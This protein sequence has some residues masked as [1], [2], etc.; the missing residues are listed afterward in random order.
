MSEP[1]SED[2][3]V[4]GS[5]SADLWISSDAEDTDLEVT[6]V[7]ARADGTEVLVQSGWLRASQRAL[8]QAASTELN[9]V[10]THIEADAAP[11]PAGELVPVRVDIFPFAH[12]FRVGSRLLVSIDAPGG[13]RQ[14]WLFDTIS[15]G[16]TV[17]IAFGAEHPSRIV[18]ATLT[19]IDF[20][21]DYPACGT[22]R[23]QPCRDG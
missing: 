15:D 17:D 4:M 8:D 13:N 19:G 18:L 14:I 16:E 20:P 9:P 22:L 12:P 10:Q 2:T 21:D 11:L 23:G 7:E 6:I 5:G 1:F 3:V